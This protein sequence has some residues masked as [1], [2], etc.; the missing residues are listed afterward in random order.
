MEI[1]TY[2]L[3][4][5]TRL[6][7]FSR[8]R[9]A[10]ARLPWRSVKSGYHSKVRLEEAK[11]H[12][13]DEGLRPSKGESRARP[14]AL[15]FAAEKGT[16]AQES[17]C[18]FHFLH[19]ADNRVFYEL[20]ACGNPVLQFFQQ[21]L[22]PLLSHLSCVGNSCNISNFTTSAGDRWPMISV[23]INVPGRHKPCPRKMVNLTDKHY[24]P[25]TTPLRLRP[26][27]NPVMASMSSREES[28]MPHFKS[29]A[30]ND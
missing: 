10:R 27:N 23:S 30:R 17:Q 16:A 7:V 5:G 26:I 21:R 18:T 6:C 24:V 2:Y 12:G 15:H 28:P 9:Q 20:K 8:E 13:E 25:M 22:L 3:K 19:F 11:P 29:K 4:K 14:S 1:S